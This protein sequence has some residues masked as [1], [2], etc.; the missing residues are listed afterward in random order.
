MIA[1]LTHHSQASAARLVPAL[2]AI[3]LLYACR[4]VLGLPG[5]L[6]PY[7]LHRSLQ[8]GRAIATALELGAI[9]AVV[10]SGMVGE[11][12]RGTLTGLALAAA[13]LARLILFELRRR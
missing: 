9:G 13:L 8:G 7:L 10:A 5:D 12:T 2:L 11:Q 6:R 4:F 1:N 3:P